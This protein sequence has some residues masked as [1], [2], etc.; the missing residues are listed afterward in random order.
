MINAT[1]EG[2]KVEVIGTVIGSETVSVSAMIFRIGDFCGIV[3][4]NKQICL[5]NRVSEVDKIGWRIHA[6]QGCR[7]AGGDGRSSG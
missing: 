7:I 3:K 6:K 2:R 4:R 1:S 5:F